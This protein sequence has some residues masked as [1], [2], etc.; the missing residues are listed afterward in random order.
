MDR[1]SR[2]LLQDFV[3]KKK[4]DVSFSTEKF[5]PERTSTRGFFYCE[6]LAKMLFFQFNPTE[7]SFDKKHTWE[8]RAYPGRMHTEPI[9]LNGD[10][11][12]ISFTL[13]FDATASSAYN[14]IGLFNIETGDFSSGNTLMEIAISPV[15]D[16]LAEVN[17]KAPNGTLPIIELLES[18][19]YPMLS[20]PL[21][22]RFVNGVAKFDP[23]GRFLPPPTVTFVYGP[24]AM[25]AKLGMSFQHIL[26]NSDLAPVRTEVKIDLNVIEGVI[27]DTAKL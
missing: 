4:H 15:S 12:N 2:M 21:T 6:S 26:F 22:P 16:A 14:G 17:M 27:V 19:S 7:V 20:N 24:L 1:L 8:N 23:A 5:W 25:E 10:V 18:F 9:W 13:M 11:R 3:G